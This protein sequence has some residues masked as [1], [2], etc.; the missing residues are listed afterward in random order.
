MTDGGP[1]EQLALLTAPVLPKKRLKPV[2]DP[3]P[4]LPI[5]RVAVDMPLAHLDRFFDYMVP[6]SLHDAAVR[7]S[8]I[9]VRFAGKQVDGFIVQRVAS[10][11]HQG[12]LG[13]VLKVVSSEPVL[14]EGVV[15]S[16]IHISEPTRQAE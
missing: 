10:T 13:V 1:D 8:R 3:A 6:A 14:S 11:D 2:E 4:E 5:A 15:L 12:K 9:K 16:L 7:G